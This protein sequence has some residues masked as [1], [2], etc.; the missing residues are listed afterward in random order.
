MADLKT[1]S[2]ASDARE[3]LLTKGT[4]TAIE[5]GDGVPFIGAIVNDL[6]TGGVEAPLSAEQGKVLQESKEDADSTILKEGDVEDS[7]NST[8]T[9]NPLSANQGKQLND[10]KASLSELGSMSGQDSDDV[11]I[12]GG[13]AVLNS[14]RNAGI[15]FPSGS[16]PSVSGNNM[17]FFNTG[18]VTMEDNTRSLF[19]TPSSAESITGMCF[20]SCDP[21]GSVTFGYIFYFYYNEGSF[22]ATKIANGDSMGTHSANLQMNGNTLELVT[23]YSGGIGGAVRGNVSGFV[24][25]GRN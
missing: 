8:S 11:D 13:A 12:T 22:T 23:T 3:V 20:V 15:H 6:T 7:L 2:T 4:G 5:D 9:T 1:K 17:S 21:G 16:N 19:T 25:V 14:A 18:R 24:N 10:D